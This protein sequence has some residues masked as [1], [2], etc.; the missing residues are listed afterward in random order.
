MYLAVA[1]TAPRPPAVKHHEHVTCVAAHVCRLGVGQQQECIL[2]AKLKPTLKGWSCPALPCPALP[3]PDLALPA[4]PCP[5]RCRPTPP[6]ILLALPDQMP[7]HPPLYFV[8]C[9][10]A[11]TLFPATLYYRLGGFYWC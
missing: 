11:S 6:C 5:T 2:A 1:C 3:C 8:A 7:P 9:G 10:H 4:W